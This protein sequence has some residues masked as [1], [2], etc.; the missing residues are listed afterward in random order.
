MGVK[1]PG[2]GSLGRSIDIEVNCYKVEALDITVY[3][4]DGMFSQ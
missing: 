2:F 4:Y 1:R 3:Q